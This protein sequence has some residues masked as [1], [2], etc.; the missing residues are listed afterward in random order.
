MEA[1]IRKAVKRI[2]SRWGHAVHETGWREHRFGLE[3]QRRKGR[4]LGKALD[5]PLGGGVPA[6]QEGVVQAG[7]LLARKAAV[8]QRAA[9]IRRPTAYCSTI[10]SAS[11]SSRL[12]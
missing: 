11:S 7:E 5:I 10:L 2:G 1:P 4:F 9:T 6:E 12:A 3:E 8:V